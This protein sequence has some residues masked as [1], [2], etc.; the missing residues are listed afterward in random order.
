MTQQ[1]NEKS[2]YTPTNKKGGRN[3]LPT[4]KDVDNYVDNKP[5]PPG[6]SING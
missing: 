6:K 3:Q 1:Q 5:K 2:I 4:G